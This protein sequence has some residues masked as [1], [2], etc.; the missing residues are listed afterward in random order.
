MYLLVFLLQF[1]LVVDVLLGYTQKKKQNHSEIQNKLQPTVQLKGANTTHPQHHILLT[2]QTR[3]VR[4]ERRERG[5]LDL[6]RAPMFCETVDA[7]NIKEYRL[8]LGP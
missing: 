8:L 7:T 1:V 3:K 6:I 4:P 2:Q 5:G